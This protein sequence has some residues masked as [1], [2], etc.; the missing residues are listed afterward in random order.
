MTRPHT[1]LVT[2]AVMLSLFL[3]SM[4]VTVVGTA[5]PTIVSQL[6]GLASY[7]WVFSAYLLAS[8]TTVPIYG[9]LSDLYGRRP[10]Y[11]FAMALFLVG[12][13]LSGSA[14]SMTQLILARAVQ[15]LGAGGLLP[16]AFII[17]GDM[18]SLE[19]R[20]RVQGLF[21]SVWGVSSIIGPL[22]GGFLVDRVSWRWVFYINLVPGLIAAALFW[23]GWGRTG[24]RAGKTIKVD[25]AGAALLSLSVVL[26]LLGLL[27]PSSSGSAQDSSG[28]APGNIQS[29]LLIAGAVV[30]FLLLILVERRAVDPILPITLFRDRLFLVA[31]LNGIFV[32]AAIF[33]G[34]SYVPLFAQTVLGTTATAAGATL[35]PQMICWVVASII[36]SRLLLRVNYRTLVLFGMAIAVIGAGLVLFA[37]VVRSPIPLL[38]GMGLTGV[39]MGFTIPSF[40]IAVQSAVQRQ[41]LGTATSTLTFSRNI[42]GTLGVSIMGAILTFGLATALA[43]SGMDT[44]A[45]SADALRDPL[46]D[47]ASVLIDPVLVSAL[48]QALQGV[49]LFSLVAAALGLIVA[50]FA[51]RGSV[52]QLEADRAAQVAEQRDRATPTLPDVRRPAQ[53][54]AADLPLP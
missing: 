48:A 2:A 6:G 14:A 23:F 52:R 24:Q 33:G 20:A 51:P 36:S 21:S 39:G 49:F 40:L 41:S 12:S 16:L 54:A 37:D 10:V 28:Q 3:A 35:T 26:L 43:A 1:I 42:G 47:S 19:Q 46:A 45:V 9:K 29:F 11:M 15:G 27:N 13:L 25:F 31:C 22:I 4:E 38:V 18:F 34:A 5:M 53:G 44:G 8:T 50:W 17:I 30:S 32:G 7:S